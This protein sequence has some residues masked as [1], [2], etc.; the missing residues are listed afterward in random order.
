M[1]K[2]SKQHNVAI[3]KPAVMHL[4][5]YCTLEV[6]DV[7][8]YNNFFENKS[9]IN[10]KLTYLVKHTDILP[11]Y[12]KI[13]ANDRLYDLNVL[14]A[15]IPFKKTETGLTFSPNAQ[16]EDEDYF[17]LS[18]GKQLELAD[19]DV[20]NALFPKELPEMVNFYNQPHIEN[21]IMYFKHPTKEEFYTK[22]HPQIFPQ[23][24]VFAIPLLVIGNKTPLE[25][26]RE[27]IINDSLDIDD[28]LVEVVE[29]VLGC[30]ILELNIDDLFQYDAYDMPLITEKFIKDVSDAVT[31][32]KRNI[33]QFMRYPVFV[34]KGNIRLSFATFDM[35]CSFFSDNEDVLL[36]YKIY[37]NQLLAA[38]S[39]LTDEG[40]EVEQV[41]GQRIDF[42]HE[43]EL[44]QQVIENI[45]AREALEH[46]YYEESNHDIER[47]EPTLASL[48]C[49]EIDNS[50]L[51][52]ITLQNDD[53][54]IV[55]QINAYITDLN[56]GDFSDD[57]DTVM[58][59]FN[60]LPYDIPKIIEDEPHPFSYC[61]N[62]MKVNG[63]ILE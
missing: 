22:K 30:E 63:L 34:S 50:P 37:S 60:A 57:M 8:E 49:V 31:T 26:F 47:G 43:P 38:T 56:Q 27:T 5:F 52:I 29:E 55:R 3:T 61:P 58:E 40:Y 2:K 42:F 54:N 53:G 4:T 35:F 51:F 24:C 19:D 41:L 59:Y 25:K 13:I 15:E 36:E 18:Y 23:T 9:L 16:P 12:L 6:E 28:D 21:D 20:I 33:V 45:M 62:H 32:E 39:I 10:Q 11:K 7:E 17:A 14:L 1:S 46:I 44:Q 48:V